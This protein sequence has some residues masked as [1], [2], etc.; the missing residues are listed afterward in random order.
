MKIRFQA[1]ADLNKA[2]IT[3]VLRREPSMDFE[4]AQAAGLR[5]LR[6]LEVLALASRHQRAL[7]TH[8]VS[9]M[10]RQFRAFLD[11]GNHSPGVFLVPQLLEVSEAI[12]EIL[13][14]WLASEASDWEDRL[15][16]LPL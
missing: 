14:I 9:T 15:S 13:L 12:E 8:D 2:I 4:T 6:D 1:D 16:W 7:V 10:P 5:G 3:G 11:A